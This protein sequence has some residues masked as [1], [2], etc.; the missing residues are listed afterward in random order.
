MS[1]TESYLVF[2]VSALK[3]L[4]YSPISFLTKNAKYFRMPFRHS[5]SEQS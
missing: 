1:G 3:R 4:H 2:S 5:I